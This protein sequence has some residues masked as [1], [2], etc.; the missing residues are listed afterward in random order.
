MRVFH[1]FKHTISTFL[2][3]IENQE[4][5]VLASI[6]ELEQGAARVRV[7]RKRCE[8]RIEQLEQRIAAREVE[9]KTWR[10]RVLRSRDDRERALECVH[11]LRAA[12]HARTAHGTE[13]E[14]QRTLR[15]KVARDENA[16]DAKL[17]DLRARC[18]N[19]SSREVRASAHASGLGTGD[20]EA[21]FDRWEARLEGVDGGDDDGDLNDGFARKFSR[22]EEDAASLAELERIFASEE[23]KS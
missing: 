17:A 9:A 16:I 3:Q 18:A 11:R 10:E 2:D 1:S 12:E 7:H 19:L 4:A 21:V 14:Q 23:V 20:I 22:E 13:L 15:D 8:R 6:R 5:V